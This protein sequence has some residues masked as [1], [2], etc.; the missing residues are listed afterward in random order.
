MGTLSTLL[1]LFFWGGG[2]GGGGY[3]T[4]CW[5]MVELQVTWENVTLMYMNNHIFSKILAI[6]VKFQYIEMHAW[7]IA[8]L[9]TFTLSF[10]GCSDN[11]PNCAHCKETAGT[12]H[13]L[14]CSTEYVLKD[15]HTECIS[16]YFN[17]A[18]S[19]GRDSLSI[20]TSY[21]NS[22][23][24]EATRLIHWPMGTHS[25]DR[26]LS[27]EQMPQNPIDDKSTLVQI[28]AWCRQ[29][30]SHYMNQCWLRSLLP[31]GVTKPQ[32]MNLIS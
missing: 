28:M 7:M 9:G 16:E 15:D 11:F 19:E 12:F 14:A 17:N 30:T 8:C 31:Y 5:K 18:I 1:A 29:T 3:W 20:Q 6:S 27:D 22:R 26:L 10:P 24:T 13:C 25:K 4:S 2:G 23:T 32:W 21:L